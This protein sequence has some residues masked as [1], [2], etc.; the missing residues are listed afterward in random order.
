MKV[1]G[2]EMNFRGA[3]NKVKRAKNL[4]AEISNLLVTDPPYSYF[5]ETDIR[6]LTKSTFAKVDED[7]Y[8]MVV[9]CC[10]DV[11]HNLRS[12]LDHAYWQAVRPHVEQKDERKIQFP[13]SKDDASLEKNIQRSLANKVSDDF[14][15]AIK[16]VR[17]FGGNDGNTLLYLIHTMNIEDKH[18]FPISASSMTNISTERIRQLIPDFPSNIHLTNISISCSGRDFV[19]KG[20]LRHKYF[21]GTVVAPTTYL[22]HKK[23]DIPV[24]IY[25]TLSELQGIA[26]VVDT[27]K[28]M[29]VEVEKVL[30]IMSD[31]LK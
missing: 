10:G 9:T 30:S 28:E 25:F 17:P 24:D 14:V 26:F 2:D 3:E 15:S 19:W 13:F 8:D 1:E 4:I 12:A 5:L 22:F 7:S 21:I 18:K 31:S 27:L 16:S 23:L 29:T 11:I 6:T 20:Q